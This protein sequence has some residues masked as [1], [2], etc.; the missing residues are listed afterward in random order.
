M[1]VTAAGVVAD[2]AALARRDRALLF[3]IAGPFWF[4][5]AYALGLLLPEPP[6]LPPAA[7]V[8]A[9]AEVLARWL[10]AEAPWYLLAFGIGLWGTAT[11]YQLYLDD[12][13]P[14]VATALRRGAAL[15]PRL[16]LASALV[17]LM[18][19]AGLL[20]WILPGLY[21][22]GRLLPVG[23]VLAAERRLSAIGAIGRGF[24]LTRGSGGALAVVTAAMLGLGWLAAE[25][26]LLL[27]GWIRAQGDG[28]NPIAIA[29]VDA[30]AAAVSAATA[31][32]SALLAVAAYR[33]L[34]R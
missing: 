14:D 6:P 11:V 34:V 28:G 7:E 10:A 8:Q 31:L 18:A 19:G 27:E 17:A 16:L 12:G 4:L 9:R 33:R 24:Q 15:W 5:P 3:A 26:L 30:G 1:R 20:L 22:L 13:R 2:A 23:P 29:V 25:P 21:V 32:A